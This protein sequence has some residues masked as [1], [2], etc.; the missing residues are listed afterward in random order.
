M[1]QYP[2]SI[3]SVIENVDCLCP[4]IWRKLGSAVKAD[5]LFKIGSR[6]VACIGSLALS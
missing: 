3:A 4:T 2:L 5:I 1:I 6:I